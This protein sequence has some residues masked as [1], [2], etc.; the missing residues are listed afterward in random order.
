MTEA[1]NL[2]MKAQQ[3]LKQ[4]KIVLCVDQKTGIQAIE[5]LYPDKLVKAGHIKSEPRKSQGI[6]DKGNL[7]EERL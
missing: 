3:Y 1:I 6:P 2:Y 5:R 7:H 4:N